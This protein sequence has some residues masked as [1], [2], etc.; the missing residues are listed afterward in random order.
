MFHLSKESKTICVENYRNCDT[1]D[2]NHSL[3]ADRVSNSLMLCPQLILKC[4]VQSWTFPLQNASLNIHFTVACGLL[5]CFLSSRRR[6][7]HRHHRPIKKTR[8][9]PWFGDPVLA[10]DISVR[11]KVYRAYDNYA[12]DVSHS[13]VQQS[14][15]TIKFKIQNC[16]FRYMM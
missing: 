6:F 8:L 9:V 13:H 4:R 16:L 2:P 7:K 10:Y 14:I 3:H 5:C 1:Q 12:A 15:K 11:D